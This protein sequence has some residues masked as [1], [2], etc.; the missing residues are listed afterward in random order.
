MPE[1]IAPKKKKQTAAGTA[2]SV[3][4]AKPT[5]QKKKV[6]IASVMK[7]AETVVFADGTVLSKEKAQ[8]P[9]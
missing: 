9:L 5:Q 7:T 3:K 6:E 2:P 1:I 8:E 4:K